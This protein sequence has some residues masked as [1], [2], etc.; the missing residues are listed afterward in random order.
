MVKVV[1]KN[2]KKSEL[3]REVT[4][5]RIEKT[6][7]KF[8]ELARMAATVIVSREHSNEHSGASLFSAKLMLAGNGHKPLILEKRAESL[9]QALALVTDRAAEIFQRALSKD[10][11]TGRHRKRRWKSFQKWKN[12]FTSWEEGA[13][14]AS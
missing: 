9:Y 5:E 1:F 2:L 4:T 3:V 10:R 7:S 8:S 13:E 12:D 14:S 6:I 11:E